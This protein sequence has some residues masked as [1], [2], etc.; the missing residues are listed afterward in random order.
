MAKSFNELGQ[1]LKQYL[2]DC[3]SNYQGLKNI[4]VERYN[5]LKVFMEPEIYQTFHVIIRVGISEAVFIM[6]ESVVFAGS[7]GMDEKF[8]IRWLQNT[9]IQEDLSS[10]WKNARLYSS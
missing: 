9:F 4:S 3:H 5:N 10:H 7:M 1:H 6:P 2:I 8:V